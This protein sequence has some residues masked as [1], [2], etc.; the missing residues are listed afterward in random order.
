M[1]QVSKEIEIF[2]K[3]VET[4]KVLIAD[5]SSSARSGIYRVIADMGA[6]PTQIFL[7]NNYHSAI[8]EMKLRKPHIVIAEYDFGSSCGLEL[9]QSQRANNPESKDCLFILITGNTS[10]STVARAA[11]EDVDAF[12]LKPFTPDVLRKT[13]LSVALAKISPPPY[14][15]TINEG[16]ALLEAQDLDAAE[17]KFKTA[18]TLDPR[19][20]LAYYYLGQVK[21]LREILN[22]AQ[23]DYDTGLNYN[24]IHYKCMV[25]LYDIFMKT[26]QHDRAYDVVKKISQ[27]FPANPKRLSEVLRL[28]IMNKKYEDVEKYY[29]IFCN[30]DERSELLINYICAALVVCGKYYLQTRNRS[31]A[32]ELF[33]KAGATSAGR[34]KILREIVQALLDHRLA[35]EATQFLARFPVETHTSS[36]YQILDFLIANQISTISSILTKGRD[37]L[38]KGVKDERVY[39]VMIARYIEGKLFSAADDL[40]SD[41]IAKF[42][43]S[44]EKFEKLY[45]VAKRAQEETGTE[46]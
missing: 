40:L 24:K 22:E 10:Q 19:P 23:G 27:Y 7:A 43:D 35:T 4:R 1:L 11:E 15:L 41:A 29:Q 20:S 37:L 18:T 9:L 17:E 21:F 30:I 14:V 31:R 2:K 46:G 45:Q 28:A 38:Q 3:Y 6:P 26:Q 34:T 36:E 5:A 13:I 33:Q 25:G 42:P 39:E 16:K 8:E 12:V 44:K 32:L